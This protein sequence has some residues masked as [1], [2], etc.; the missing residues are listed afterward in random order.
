MVIRVAR[1]SS[2][3][4]RRLSPLKPASDYRS[5]FCQDAQRHVQLVQET[6]A[7]DCVVTIP[8]QIRNLSFLLNDALA[9]LSN[10]PV[11]FL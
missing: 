2:Q 9:R 10:L 4:L 6:H 8:L 7:P 1:P 5:M 3:C 11:G